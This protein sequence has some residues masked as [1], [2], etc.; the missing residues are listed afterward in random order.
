MDPTFKVGDVP[1]INKIQPSW[2]NIQNIPEYSN[3][4]NMLDCSSKIPAGAG[5][6]VMKYPWTV[7]LNYRRTTMVQT[8]STKVMPWSIKSNFLSFHT[9]SM[10]CFFSNTSL[11]PPFVNHP[12]KNWSNLEFFFLR[13]AQKNIGVYQ[14]KGIKWEISSGLQE[15]PA[16]P[17]EVEN[18]SLRWDDLPIQTLWLSIYC[19][20]CKE[21]SS[22]TTWNKNACHL[23]S[24]AKLLLHTKLPHWV[25]NASWIAEAGTLFLWSFFERGMFQSI[26]SYWSPSWSG[27]W[28]L[29]TQET[30]C[31]RD[32]VQFHATQNPRF[33]FSTGNEYQQALAWSFCTC[34]ICQ[35]HCLIINLHWS[36]CQWLHFSITLAPIVRLISKLFQPSHH[37]QAKIL[38]HSDTLEVTL[39]DF[40]Q[41]WTCWPGKSQ[42]WPFQVAEN[43]F[44][45][46]N[47]EGNCE[48]RS[49]SLYLSKVLKLWDLWNNLL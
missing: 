20:V 22:E 10:C 2:P 30:C 40:H 26:T 45:Q 47:T 15:L 1:L 34:F 9:V 42:L 49:N 37:F 44:L 43:Q 41:L 18:K 3:S 36:K 48:K 19:H 38:G 25:A 14:T 31:K 12:C 23:G 16:G 7:Y 39:D 8:T 13:C 21:K 6:I 24:V 33:K 11:I 17:G 5:G 35:S 4:Q 28:F 27:I 29:W 32:S 46:G